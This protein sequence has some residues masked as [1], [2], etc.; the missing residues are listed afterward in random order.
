MS[1]FCARLAMAAMLP[2]WQY[3]Q[4][5][6]VLLSLSLSLTESVLVK[7]TLSLFFGSN[8]IQTVWKR[9]EVK[10][11]RKS[12]QSYINQEFICVLPVDSMKEETAVQDIDLNTWMTLSFVRTGPS[13]PFRRRPHSP[14][15]L[16][17]TYSGY[18]TIINLIFRIMRLR[19]H[20]NHSF[21]L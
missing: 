12:L 11:A 19:I 4:S 3:R 18:M 21:D 9:R 16:Y 10:T 6:F 7:H 15:I 5:H 8:N 17:S 1:L 20:D 14:I 2:G 13:I